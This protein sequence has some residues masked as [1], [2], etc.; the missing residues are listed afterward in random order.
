MTRQGVGVVTRIEVDIIMVEFDDFEFP[1]SP[2]E[3]IRADASNSVHRNEPAQQRFHD[4]LFN[5]DNPGEIPGRPDIDL[6]QKTSR[7]GIPVV[8]L[9]F[10]SFSRSRSPLSAGEKLEA[11]LEHLKQALSTADRR[12]MREFFVIHGIG[13][14][15]LESTVRDYL[16]GLNRVVVE[17][18]PMREFGAGAIHVR[19]VRSKK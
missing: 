14:G 6:T 1:F 17:D 11:Q 5:H 19:I 10:E 2:S 4:D 15:V 16:A 7:K 3:V 13:K 9:H 18:A 12:N 8:D